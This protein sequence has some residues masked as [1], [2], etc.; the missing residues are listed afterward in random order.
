MEEF[1]TVYDK[2][3]ELCEERN[4]KVM[5]YGCMHI[6]EGV[7]IDMELNNLFGKLIENEDFLKYI[8]E[9][10]FGLESELE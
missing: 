3:V 8:R 2:Y 4:P 1:W 5:G 9:E 10:W 7:G 6:V